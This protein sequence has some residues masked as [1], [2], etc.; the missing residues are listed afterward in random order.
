M[1]F[2]TGWADL[3][4]WLTS[5]LEVFGVSDSVVKETSDSAFHEKPSDD[6][7]NLSKLSSSGTSGLIKD[8]AGLSVFRKRIFD[9]YQRYYIMYSI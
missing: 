2:A 1:I 4:F 5:Y 6:F 3:G 7:I 9:Q 8:N